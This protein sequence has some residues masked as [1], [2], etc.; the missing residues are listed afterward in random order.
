[1][2]EAVT[3]GPAR[4]Y[5]RR[6]LAEQDEA[7]QIT[8]AQSAV[9]EAKAAKVAADACTLYSSLI[10]HRLRPLNYLWG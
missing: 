9:V 10:A 8:T 6:S 1:M 2:A 5:R 4:F 7:F 3:G